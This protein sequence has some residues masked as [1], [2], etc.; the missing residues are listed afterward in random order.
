MLATGWSEFLIA[1]CGFAFVEVSPDWIRIE[2]MVRDGNPPALLLI[3]CDSTPSK[4]VNINLEKLNAMAYVRTVSV[5]TNWL[6]F[7][8]IRGMLSHRA[9]QEVLREAVDMVKQGQIY[10]DMELLSRI[11]QCWA[12]ATRLATWS[13]GKHLSPFLSRRPYRGAGFR[14]PK[15]LRPWSP[16]PTP[17]PV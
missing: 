13:P 11:Q 5:G 12:A 4:P 6:L 1:Y 8:G 2:E 7:S 3:D 14:L 10:Y 15:E 16:P 9:S 17:T